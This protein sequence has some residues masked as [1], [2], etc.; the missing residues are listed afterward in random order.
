MS[1]VSFAGSATLPRVEFGAPLS[2]YLFANDG[3]AAITITL[4]DS[5][6]VVQPGETLNSSPYETLV[7]LAVTGNAGSAAWRFLGAP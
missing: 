3:A 1:K 6:F 4:D 2:S 5:V 7:S